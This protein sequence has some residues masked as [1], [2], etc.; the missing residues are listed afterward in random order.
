MP[1]K[2]K[3]QFQLFMDGV[4]PDSALDIGSQIVDYSNIT[5]SSLENDPDKAEQLYRNLLKSKG[6]S[7][8]KN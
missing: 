5:K 8:E 6:F 2:M 7:D 1:S 4:D 3:K